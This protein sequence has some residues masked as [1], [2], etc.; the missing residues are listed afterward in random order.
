MEELRVSFTFEQLIAWISVRRNVPMLHPLVKSVAE[1]V[2]YFSH[3][4]SHMLDLSLSFVSI[5]SWK[6]SGPLRSIVFTYFFQRDL[7]QL[8]VKLIPI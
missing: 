5:C 3:A 1:S 7:V 6:N 4:E 8:W 2:P